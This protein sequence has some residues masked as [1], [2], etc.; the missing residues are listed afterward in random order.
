[1]TTTWNNIAWIFEQN[2]SFRDIYIQ[3]VSLDDW[4]R[5]IDFLNEHYPLRYA[6]NSMYKESDQI[7]KEYALNYLIDNTREKESKSVTIEITGVNIN[8]HFFL[9]DQIEFDVDPRE[10]KSIDD[11]DKVEE[12]MISVSRMLGKQ[13][14][15]TDENE[16]ELP[17]IKIDI[18]QGVHKVLSQEE[19]NG[20]YKSSNSL[21]NHFL[22]IRTRLLMKFFPKK[23]T[24]RLERSGEKP[25]QSTKKSNN[26]W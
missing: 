5:M 4:A 14:T 8:C 9:P 10:I 26:L 7:D 22:F 13:V 3:D 15:L 24:K 16:I 19:R 20:F 12:F 18:K 23:F 2:G 1:M 17:L 6:I 11:Y 25:Y 21:K